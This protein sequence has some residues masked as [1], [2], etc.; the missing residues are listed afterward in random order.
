MNDT[1]VDPGGGPEV[2]VSVL[3][4]L[5][6]AVETA[7][8]TALDADPGVL[9]VRRCA[10]LAELLAAAQAGLASVV[11]VSSGFGRVDAD[12]IARLHHAGCRVIGVVDPDRDNS[13]RVRSLGVDTVVAWSILDDGTGT[14]ALVAAVADQPEPSPLPPGDPTAR[15]HSYSDG[16]PGSAAT[17]RR[18]RR[19]IP[20]ATPDAA[21]PDAAAPDA[22]AWVEVFDDA[23]APAPAADT[24]DTGSTHAAATT[25]GRSDDTAPNGD[26][27]SDRNATVITVWG[28]PG[29]PG[30]TTVAVTLA[31]ELA[32]EGVD[33]LLIDADTYAA[34]IASFLGML[35]ESSGI[36]AAVRAGLD[37]RLDRSVLTGFAPEVMPRLRVLTGITRSAR[38]SELRPAGFEALLVAAR[39]AADVVVIDVAS[40]LERD[41]EMTYD[42][43]APRRNALTLQAIERSD[44]L[45]AVG[46]ADPIGLQRLVR[47]LQELQALEAG[48][49]AIVVANRVRA[50][51][52]GDAPAR[53]VEQ[54]LARFAGVDDLVCV[55]DDRPGLDRALLMGRSL[56][57]ASPA[58]AVR[59]P[60]RRLAAT[61]TGRTLATAMDRS[62]RRRRL[63]A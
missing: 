5:D 51:A 23:P 50:S 14:A 20:S 38:W 44:A 26:D 61:V 36:V 41:E 63:G 34:S 2:P 18:A 58:S 6:G 39:H 40:S 11:V 57:E 25:V 16:S 15:D 52:V 60:L 59:A 33:V 30:R 9:V 19:A 4:A 31:S 43:S 49:P 46:S 24:A 56:L 17:G 32:A 48:P 27:A 55:P 12:A 47:A 35:D 10:D 54:A 45:I 8:A 21:A 29:A 37:G 22:S 7:A 1:P 28:A 3:I 42:V 53:R 13:D 62:R